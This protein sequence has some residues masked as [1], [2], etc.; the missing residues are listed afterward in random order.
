M[1]ATSFWSA[2]GRIISAEEFLHN[3]YGTLPDFF[4]NEDELRTIWSNPVTRKTLLEKLADAGFG[5]D[6]LGV[7]QRL[8]QAENSDL[9]DVLEYISFAHQPRRP[10]CWGR[11]DN[12]CPA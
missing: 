1:M 4:N 2:D 5:Q 3:L 6:E 8:V 7:L 10:G 12:L 9:F 11:I